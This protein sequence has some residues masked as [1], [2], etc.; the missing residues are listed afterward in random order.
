MNV[1]EISCKFVTL[2]VCKLLHVRM[3][4]KYDA[5]FLHEVSEKNLIEH[6]L[7]C[8]SLLRILSVK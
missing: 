2:H 8:D 7:I 4:K 3:I 1:L 5:W 6:I